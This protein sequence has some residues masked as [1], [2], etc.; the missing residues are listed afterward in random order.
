MRV[1]LLVLLLV[2]LIGAWFH[3]GMLY[4]EARCYANL[5]RYTS[6]EATLTLGIPRVA[7]KW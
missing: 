1:V 3:A 4:A 5:D 7:C 6:V 2:G